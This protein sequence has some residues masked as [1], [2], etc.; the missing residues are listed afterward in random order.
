MPGGLRGGLGY[1]VYMAGRIRS[2]SINPGGKVRS[3]SKAVEHV[4]IVIIISAVGLMV[5]GIVGGMLGGVTLMIIAGIICH[6]HI[7]WFI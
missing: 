2:V 3:N 6:R 4:I 7:D 5:G 1:L